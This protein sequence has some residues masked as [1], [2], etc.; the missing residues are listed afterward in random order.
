MQGDA[1]II[2]YQW[3][4]APL[5]AEEAGVLADRVEQGM[6]KADEARKQVLQNWQEGM[7]CS[8]ASWELPS[9]SPH[10]HQ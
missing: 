8:S 10:M 1:M 3:K 2:V 9:P 7:L 6:L 4:I 5:L